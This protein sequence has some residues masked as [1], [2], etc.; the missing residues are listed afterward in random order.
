[1]S[2]ISRQELLA[3]AKISTLKERADRS[4]A[5]RRQSAFLAPPRK[6]RY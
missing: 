4:T 6:A 2:R 5:L 1:M 3:G